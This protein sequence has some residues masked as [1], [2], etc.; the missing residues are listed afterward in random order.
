MNMK[1]TGY[2][3]ILSVLSGIILQQCYYDNRDDLYP[4]QADSVVTFADDIEPFITGSCASTP[5]CHADGSTLP[6]LETYDQITANIAAIE[7]RAIKTKTMPPSGPANQ[8]ELDGL[9]KW[10]DD[11]MPNN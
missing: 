3:L 4:T 7:R 2:L 9:Q 1:R 10:I 11:G 6:V 8:Q 5:S